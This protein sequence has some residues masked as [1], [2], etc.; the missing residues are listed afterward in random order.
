[1]GRRTLLK[2]RDG[3]SDPL[4]GLERV[5]GTS[6]RSRMGRGT[7]QR[8]GTDRGTLGVVWDGLGEPRGGLGRVRGPSGRFRMGRGPHE[9]SGTGRGSLPKNRDGRGT[10]GVD[11]NGSG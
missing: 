10:L 1:M 2:F 3:L 4:S 5:G 7:S 6:G 8:F 11:W 9:R